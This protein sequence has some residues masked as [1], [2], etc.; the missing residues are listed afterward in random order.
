MHTTILLSYAQATKLEP[1]RFLGD[2]NR[3]HRPVVWCRPQQKV[4]GAPRLIVSVLR[5]PIEREIRQ[6]TMRLLLFTGL[7]NNLLVNLGVQWE[8]LLFMEYY[9]QYRQ[10][11][12]DTWSDQG[13]TNSAFALE[14]TVYPHLD[15]LLD[16]R[17]I[18][19]Y[20]DLGSGSFTL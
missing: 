17:L 4:C 18:C 7:D 12:K 20:Y 16:L 6:F 13:Q 3:P 10:R 8:L 15:T 14:R 5:S 2:S 19:G 11:V 9:S 1:A